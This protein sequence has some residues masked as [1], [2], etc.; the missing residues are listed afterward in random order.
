MILM[1]L[2]IQHKNE[3]QSNLFNINNNNKFTYND[4]NI[5]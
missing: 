4:N 3:P 2:Y 5:Y 1:L